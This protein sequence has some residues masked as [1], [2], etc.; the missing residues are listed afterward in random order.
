MD[1]ISNN[2]QKINFLYQSIFDSQTTIR[3]IDVKT[4]FLFIIIFIPL[5]EVKT[6][7]E[8]SKELTQ[9]SSLYWLSII[10]VL[11]L[12]ILSAISLFSCSVSISNPKEHIKGPTPNGT[13]F[14]NS[15]YKFNFVDV[16]IN[17]PIKS[18]I[19]IEEYVKQ[20]P[21]S[22]ESFIKELS[23]EKMKLAYIRDIKIKRSSFSALLSFCWVIS[24]GITWILFLLK[25]GF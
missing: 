3:A 19:S 6:I 1:E 22:E 21:C 4:G 5:S 9:V 10:S 24:G 23:F 16:F 20:L 14:T 7:L 17:F 12:W 18:S 2:Q 25:V 13:F 8:I 11:L 15:L